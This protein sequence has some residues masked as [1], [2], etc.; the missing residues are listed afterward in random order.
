MPPPK[1]CLSYALSALAMF[2]LLMTVNWGSYLVLG[3]WFDWWIVLALAV[4]LTA[5]GLTITWD[6]D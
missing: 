2:V 5:V 6:D 1:S 3:G 4:I